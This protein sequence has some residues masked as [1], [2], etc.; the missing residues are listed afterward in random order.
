M[1]VEPVIII[2]VSIILL[3]TMFSFYVLNRKRKAASAF[4][5]KTTLQNIPTDGIEIPILQSYSGFKALAPITFNGNNLNPKL[6]FYA[7]HFEYKVLFKK[8]AMYAD[9]ESIRSYSSRYF[10]T[11]QIK[12]HNNPVFFKAVF[13]NPEVLRCVVDFFTER[14]IYPDAKSRSFI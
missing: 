14:G 2:A 10:N 8:S 7:D 5:E 3:T 4:V 13:G 11:L 12:F 6:I 9:V 1:S